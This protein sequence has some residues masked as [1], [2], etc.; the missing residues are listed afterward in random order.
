M[1]P[2]RRARAIAAPHGFLGRLGGVSDGLYASLNVG[3]GSADDSAAVAEN[4]RRA[5]AAVAPDARLVTVHQVH[6]AVAVEAGD[7]PDHARPHAD[8]LVTDRPG[9][10]LGILT[11]DCAPVLFHDSE[12]GVIGAAHAGWKG[13]LAGILDSAVEAMVRLGARRERIAAAIGPTI[14]RRSYEVDRGFVERFEAAEP[15]NARFFT[16]GREGHALFDLEGYCTHRLARCGLG[17]IEALGEDTLARPDRYFSYRRA[18]LARE[19]D[20]GRQ[21]SLIALP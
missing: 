15:A 19:P 14:G 18:T 1:I 10:A 11:A 20:Y 4:R 12:A 2:V 17:T 5:L 16:A 3:L 6:G 7:W 21:I 13:A 8:A 9:L